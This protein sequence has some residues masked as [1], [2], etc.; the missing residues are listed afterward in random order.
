M[1][2]YVLKRYEVLQKMVKLQNEL[3][4][5]RKIEKLLDKFIIYYELKKTE[6]AD[7]NRYKRLNIDN[8]K[9]G[10]FKLRVK[11]GLKIDIP[12]LK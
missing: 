11:N 1:T 5:L 10:L 2:N 9:E 12:D 8:R 3:T 7:A 4:E 6:P